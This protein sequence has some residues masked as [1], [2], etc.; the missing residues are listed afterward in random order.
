MSSERKTMSTIGPCI[1]MPVA[2]LKPNG[3]NARTHSRKQ[4]KQIARSIQEF[5]FTNPIIAD[6]SGTIIA[7]HGRLAAAQ[8]LGLN[9][10]PVITVS[11]LSE[12]RKRA[13]ILA[14]NKIASNAGW[15]REKLA[16]EIP[17]LTALLQAEEIEITVTG[18]EAPEIDQLL[19]DFDENGSDPIDNIEAELGKPVSREGD[20]WTLGCHRLLCGN[21]RSEDDIDRLMAG[22]LASMAFLDPPYNVAVHSVVG[23]GQTKHREFAEASGEQ[24]SSEFIAFLQTALNNAKRVSR[25][26]ALHYVCMDWRH[27]GE[28]I[29]AGALTY[30]EH[31]NTAIWVKTN[32]GQGS[33]YRS[34]HEEVLVFRVGET[35]HLNNVELGRH[36]RS[37]SNVW[38][39]PG[40]NTFRKGR[41]DDLR[42][43]P[44]VKP[45][46]LISDAMRDCT[47]RRDIVLDTFCGSGTTILAA[48]RVGRLAY[49]MEIDPI[50]V[51]VAIRRWQA[52]TGKDAVHHDTGRTF[53]ELTVD[54]SCDLK[55][56]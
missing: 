47:K 9:Q 55:V 15:D 8:T 28:L 35:P 39:Y 16:I 56:K 33:F 26:G 44:T 12:A 53:Y 4:V 29:T 45:V 23:R 46:Q 42:S 24:S 41:M 6:E 11:G 3:H 38:T 32:A 14:D 7:G 5:G 18:F 30:D 2:S 17:E 51:D 40:A 52:L 48:E 36:G 25:G 20:L 22:D 1:D 34:Q 31:V 43:H 50:Y 27:I 13:L 10:L 19:V 37:R 49:A 21:A 54:D